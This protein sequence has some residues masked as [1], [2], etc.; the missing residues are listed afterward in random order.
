MTSVSGGEILH[1]TPER[2]GTTFKETVEENGR[3]AELHGVITGYK[4]NEFMSFHL[5]GKFNVV[6]VEYYLEEI[7]DHTRLTFNSDIRFK[8][9][10]KVLMLVM[11]PLF[12]K[13]TMDQ[14]KKEFAKLKD[15]C[16]TGA[17]G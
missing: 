7:V 4:Q 2:I 3:S 9:I 11:R 6:D 13:K 15:L 8:S 10:T 1:E 16:E 12:K 14:L 5:S 17:D